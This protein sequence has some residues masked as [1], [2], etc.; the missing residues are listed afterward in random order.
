M[1]IFP[2]MNLKSLLLPSPV[3]ALLLVA[4]LTACADAELDPAP[5]R[6]EAAGEGLAV[7]DEDPFD[8]EACA[9]ISA[10]ATS[11]IESTMTCEQPHDC[12]AIPAAEVMPSS[13]IP[14]VSCYLAASSR[15]DLEPILGEL[16][17]LELEYRTACGLC[18]TVECLPEQRVMATCGDDGSCDL[19]A[20]PARSRSFEISS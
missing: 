3:H 11:L 17:A 6:D 8:Y 1:H 15:T 18:P 5:A 10:A 16:Q 19:R 12:E 13:C 2:C 7:I 4:G 14:A 9:E 20:R